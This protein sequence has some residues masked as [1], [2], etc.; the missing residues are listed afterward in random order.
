MIVLNSDLN[1]IYKFIIFLL[2]FSKAPQLSPT[3]AHFQRSKRIRKLIKLLSRS[4][5]GVIAVV[6]F[7][8][9]LGLAVVAVVLYRRKE[10]YGNPEVKRTKAEDSPESPFTDQPDSHNIPS[11]TAKEFFI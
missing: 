7:L 10:T 11:E 1:P 2:T 6:V 5:A 9:A 4:V 8:T 3:S